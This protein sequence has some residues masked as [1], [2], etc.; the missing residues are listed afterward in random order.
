M[1]GEIVDV[2][3]NYPGFIIKGKCVQ[4]VYILLKLG[5][6]VENGEIGA[7]FQARH[8]GIVYFKIDKNAKNYTGFTKMK[9]FKSDKSVKIHLEKSVHARPV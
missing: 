6:F 1:R 7:G 8:G 5:T 9:V 3:F 4:T 2:F